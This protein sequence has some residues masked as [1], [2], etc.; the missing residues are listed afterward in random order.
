MADDLEPGSDSVPVGWWR[1]AAEKARAEAREYFAA[2]Q[3]GLTEGQALT[4]K[5]YRSVTEGE[6]RG[7]LYDF[8]TELRVEFRGC[9]DPRGRGYLL[10][11]AV[12]R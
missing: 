6:L 3:P 7:W 11:G 5:L 9:R 10:V 12:K 1:A 4:G 2:K 8:R